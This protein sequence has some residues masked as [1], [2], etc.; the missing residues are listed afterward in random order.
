M[1]MPFALA[2]IAIFGITSTSR[3]AYIGMTIFTAA[4]LAAGQSNLADAS[5]GYRTETVT[6]MRPVTRTL[7][8]DEVR[9]TMRTVNETVMLERA[10]RSASGHA[11]SEEC[12]LSPGL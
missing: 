6:E 10:A 12:D 4:P 7:Y 1:R 11:A 2:M 3:A 5:Q 8:R 9:T